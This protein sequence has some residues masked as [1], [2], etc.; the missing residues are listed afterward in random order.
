MPD[1]MNMRREAVLWS[2]AIVA[3]IALGLVVVWA[4]IAL[5]FNQPNLAPL[6]FAA[7]PYRQ[8][9]YSAEGA[10]AGRLS[11][12]DPGLEQEVML[13]DQA[14]GNPVL[15]IQYDFQATPKATRRP[16]STN[17]SVPAPTN[18]TVTPGPT[19]TPEPTKA[20]KS[21][22]T[23][24]PTRT[25]KPTG[26]PKPTKEPKSTNTPEPTKEPKPTNTPEPTKAPKSTRTPK[27][28]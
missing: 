16:A 4:A 23:P 6:Y 5:A 8:D 22:N 27:P 10:D 2:M 1:L 14:R 12:L 26:T 13:E 7:A 18:T 25:P 17:T 3:A 24:E 21:T 11:P 15:N 9:D 19:K 28:T 20:P